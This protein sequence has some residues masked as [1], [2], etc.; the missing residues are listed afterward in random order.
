MAKLAAV[1][2]LCI[3]ANVGATEVN[4][5][6]KVVTMLQNMQTKIAAEG[7]KKQKMFDQYMCYCNNADGTLGKSISD[8]ETKI[9]QVASSIKEG[10]A[11]K[12]QLEAELKQ[13]QVDRVEAK[14]AIAKATA[15]REK[16]AAAYAK[17]KAE[18]E[19]N[20]GALAKAI[21]AIEKGMGGAFLQT[22]SAAVLRQ[23]SVNAN[24]IPAD[25]DLLASFLSEGSNYAPKSGEIVGILKTLHDEMTKDFADATSDENGSIASFESLV[26]SKEKE[27]QALTKAIESKT[28]RVGELGVKIA[29]E[30]NDLEDTQEGLAEDKKFL[31]DLDKNCELK[32]AEWAAYQKMQATEAVALADTIKVL[33]DDD[34]LELFKK[35]LPGAA[36]SFM[37]VQV[38]SVAVRHRAIH[39]LKATKKAD[40]RLDLIELAM[41]GGKI[42]FGKILKMID[43]LVVDLKAEQG[44]DDDKQKYCLAEFDKAED[45]KKGLDLDISDLGKAIDDGKESIA[46]FKS[47]IEALQ[48]SIKALDKS[49]AEATE[50]RKKEHDDYVETLAANSAAKDLLGFAKNRLNKFY[51][52]KMYKAPPKRELTEE[53]QI[54]VNNGGTLAPTAAP[55]GIAGTGIGLNQVAPPPPPAANLA[56]KKSGESSNGVMAMIDLIVADVDKEIQTME[57]DEKDAQQDYESFM[58]DASEKR[59]QDSKTITDKESAKAEAETELESNTDS[60]KSKTIEAMETAKYIGGLHEE[61]DWLLKN[62]GA[63]K[64][65]RAG[66]VDALGKAK[67]VLSG[68]DYSLVQTESAHLRGSK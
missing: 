52:P 35:T 49:V 11:M 20:I 67:A 6:R 1:A 18:A 54:T 46:T 40:P 13:A 33:N 63:R 16:E 59:A 44:V 12:K 43:N 62:Y 29:Q 32:K 51:N 3:L 48:D 9:P 27:I 21:P 31:G 61:C 28:M 56:Y 37:Q 42:G 22:N 68:A 15:I 39:A 23:I 50:T 10:A 64:E 5:I 4:P 14:D 58:S 47:E 55:G 45:K 41:H 36:S 19:A 30:E 53:E 8:A 25:R 38:S 17:T 26:A 34:A 65:A 24:M 57:V 60:K 2:I 7:E 66:E